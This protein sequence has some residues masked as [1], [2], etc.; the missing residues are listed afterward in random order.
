MSASPPQVYSGDACATTEKW[1]EKGLPADLSLRIA[2]HAGPVYEFNDPITGS[3][4]YTGSHVNRAARIEPITPRGQVYASEA[5]AALAAVRPTA[6]FSCDYVGQTPMAKGYGT[7]PTYHVRGNSP[8]FV[9]GD[10]R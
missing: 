1:E 4:S 2:L 5:F 3:R 10:D 7:L 6:G 8:D 9:P